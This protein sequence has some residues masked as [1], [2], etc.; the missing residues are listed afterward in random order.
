M[1]KI[2]TDCMTAGALSLSPKEIHDLL[3]LSSPADTQP[4]KCF[5]KCFGEKTFVLDAAGKPNSTTLTGS[6]MPECFD[7]AK[8]T[9]ALI[10]ECGAKTGATPCDVGYEVEKCLVEKAGAPMHSGSDEN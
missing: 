6:Q 10:T 7:K 3:H 4:K 8:M 9:D 5:V 1:V 2:V